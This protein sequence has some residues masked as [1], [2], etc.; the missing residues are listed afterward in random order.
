MDEKMEIIGGL[1]NTILKLKTK[2]KKYNEDNSNMAKQYQTL[3]QKV[4]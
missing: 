3:K 4:I 2:N 1:E